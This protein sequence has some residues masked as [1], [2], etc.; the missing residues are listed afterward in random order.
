MLCYNEY[1]VHQFNGKPLGLCGVLLYPK[2]P[3]TFSNRA[4]LREFCKKNLDFVKIDSEVHQFYEK[5]LELFS[6][7]PVLRR[8]QIYQII[9]AVDQ[10]YENPPGLFAVQFFKINLNLRAYFCAATP[11][12]VLVYFLN[13]GRVSVAELLWH[14]SFRS[15]VYCRVCL[16]GPKLFVDQTYQTQLILYLYTSS[17]QFW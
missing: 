4:V 17:I 15:T 2:K 7:R 8:C 6:K 12:N 11:R 16:H 9:P 14:L 10:F 1:E 3:W 5:A 13:G